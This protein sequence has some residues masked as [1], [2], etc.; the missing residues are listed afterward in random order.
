MSEIEK[1]RG[2]LRAVRRR[3]TLEAALRWG[4]TTW[5]VALLLVL[6]MA[7]AAARVGPASFWPKLTGTVL[8]I[9]TLLGVI[10]LVFSSMRQLRSWRGVAIFVGRRRPPIASD[11]VSAIELS[12][13]NA[14]GPG[15]QGSPGFTAAF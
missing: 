15:Q 12:Q 8:T 14:A 3:A 10:A 6:A 7:V 5:A 9:I 2:F 11:L 4:G 1:I 13:P